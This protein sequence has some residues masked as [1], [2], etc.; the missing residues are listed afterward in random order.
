[1]KEQGVTE[2]YKFTKPAEDGKSRT[3]TAKQNQLT[4]SNNIPKYNNPGLTKDRKEVISVNIKGNE[5]NAPSA[6]SEPYSNSSAKPTSHAPKTDTKEYN[7]LKIMTKDDHPSDISALELSNPI[8]SF[9]SYLLVV[10]DF[11]GRNTIWGST[12][13]NN[14]GNAG[15]KDNSRYWAM[16]VE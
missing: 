3:P 12:S 2:G 4:W 13:N 16:R 1:M 15:R 11:N 10:G 14:R 6:H 8:S 7:G 5:T 9:S